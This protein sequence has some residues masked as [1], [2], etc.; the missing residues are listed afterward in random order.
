MLILIIFEATSSLHLGARSFN[1]WK[2]KGFVHIRLAEFLL[3][4]RLEDVE[5]ILHIPID[6]SET[7]LRCVVKCV[8]SLL[9]SKSWY[10]SIIELFDL[11]SRVF[12]TFILR[13]TLRSYFPDPHILLYLVLL[14]LL[15]T[16]R[17]FF[18]IRRGLFGAID[19]LWRGHLLRR[20]FDR[21]VM[22]IAICSRSSI[23]TIARHISLSLLWCTLLCHYLVGTL[24]W[25][26]G[27]I[28]NDK[29]YNELA[30]L[31]K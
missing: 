9:I 7:L 17:D 4:L 20:I 21:W 29:L 28:Y 12:S 11:G 1:L 22:L 26:D 25:V 5:F 27:L 15:A 23:V 3:N 31:S 10:H 14:L 6:I 13:W 16:G 8:L 2:A 24:R 30:I 19:Y 18:L